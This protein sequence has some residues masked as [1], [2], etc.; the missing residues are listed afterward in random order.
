M[1][2]IFNKDLVGA[3]FDYAVFKE[4]YYGSARVNKKPSGSERTSDLSS[5]IS[6]NR[7]VDPLALLRKR[8]YAGFSNRTE[9]VSKRQSLDWVFQVIESHQFFLPVRNC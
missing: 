7:G 6:Y 3:L 2:Y 4:R 9:T 1:A 8:R 5:S